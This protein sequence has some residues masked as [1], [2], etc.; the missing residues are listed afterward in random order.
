LAITRRLVGLH[1][2]TIVVEST[3]GEGSRFTFWL[4]A[5]SLEAPEAATA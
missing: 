1:E 3:V 4:G 5:H 2:G